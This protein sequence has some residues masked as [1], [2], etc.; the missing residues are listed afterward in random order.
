M[1]AAT[2]RRFRFLGTALMLVAAVA[3]V[4]F[5]I[6]G[7][8][9]IS[10]THGG[11]SRARMTLQKRL[12][13]RHGVIFLASLDEAVP[14]DAVTIAAIPLWNA[15]RV[16]GRHGSARRVK[17]ASDSVLRQPPSSLV[18]FPRHTTFAAWIRPDAAGYVQRVFDM[19]AIQTGFAIDF[20]GSDLLATFAPGDGT[21]DRCA[22]IPFKG[23]RGFAHLA[24]VI[25]ENY[26]AVFQNGREEWRTDLPDT[27]ALPARPFAFGA[28]QHAPFKGDVDDIAIWRRALSPEEIAAIAKSRRGLLENLEPGLAAAIALFDGV[29][30][31]LDS[32][33]RVFDRLLP[34][35]GGPAVLRTEIPTV[36]VRM[37]NSVERHFRKAH[38]ESLR[39]GYRTHKAAN[40]KPAT[41]VADAKCIRGLI[42]LDDVYGI[43]R[44]AKRPA[45]VLRDDSR[46]I[47]GGSGLLR[48]YPPELHEALHPD[49]PRPLPLDAKFVKFCI[50]NSFK[51]LYVVEPFDGIGS[52]WVA[53]GP[54]DPSFKRTIGYNGPPAPCDVPPRGLSVDE[55]FR[56]TAMRVLA[57][58]QFPWSRQE[59]RFRRHELA[60]RRRRLRFHDE[61]DPEALLLRDIA[62][63]SPSPM[64]VTNDLR[65]AGI[66]G[67]V[68]WKSSDPAL[69][70]PDG[71]VH[72]PA[73]G[74]PRAVE[75]TPVRDDGTDGPALHL[76]VA[77]LK[78]AMQALF[79]HFRTPVQK[80]RRADFSCL[81][82][83]AGGA[84][85]QWLTGTGATGGGVKHRGNTSYIKGVKRS[86][87]LEFDDR[88]DW[89]GAS[90]PA[91]HV[92]LYSGYADPTRL[93][94]KIS[95]DA[96]R[97]T[98]DGVSPHF[99]P[100]VTWTEIF[101]NGVYFGVWETSRRVKDLCDE[102]TLLYKVRAQNPRQ[103]ADVNV[104]TVEC[105][106]PA[107]VASLN[108]YEPLERLFGFVSRTKGGKFATGA[109]RFFWLDNI[110][111]FMLILRFTGN[112]DG[113][114]TNQYISRLPGEERWF[115]VP[116]DY[117][118][119]FFVEPRKGKTLSNHLLQRLHKFVPRFGERAND[120]WRELRAGPLS[121]AAVFGRIDADA[122]FLAPYMD[123]EYRLLQPAGEEGTFAD[124]VAKLK[125][126]V[127]RQLKAMDE[128][129][130][131]DDPAPAAQ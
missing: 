77:P 25:G 89:P 75:L 71:T 4:F 41:I 30:A 59:L 99:A 73:S 52:A 40:F 55:A 51:G 20:D 54:R 81:R 36:S 1:A 42:A 123:E 128:A 94:N 47:I 87:S 33:Y 97:A 62:A 15:P 121:D 80:L 21:P 64:F 29:H 79:L 43:V 117:D 53:R 50:G 58:V 9:I 122:A 86:M 113:Q 110:I 100:D 101:V 48:L 14:V 90:R 28:I 83:P 11:A 56:E 129:A 8:K 34:S 32:F 16:A 6:S 27:F 116:W 104:E 106:T 12:L 114:V 98:D 131:K 49:A 35:L 118:K 44:G 95:F 119:T 63:G 3:L 10:W 37:P 2:K 23:G 74:A 60:W 112:E 78:P 61:A 39:F 13:D 22:R 108:R 5:F 84:E 125:A 31:F 102:G 91:T 72:R 96:F 66:P 107:A 124:A 57:D 82:I 67:I 127:A 26:A 92:L 19:R 45:F 70:A 65:L 24:A 105:T 88:V 111:D 69:V 115:I 120:R 17:S 85:L 76:R 103:W 18:S 130:S 68:A 7:A 93:R 109:Q 38:E 46:T 126:A